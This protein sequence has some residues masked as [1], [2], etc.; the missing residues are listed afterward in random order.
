MKDENNSTDIR[1]QEIAETEVPLQE[2]F[3]YDVISLFEFL[4]PS[5]FQL[6]ESR[7]ILRRVRDKDYQLEC[8][9]RASKEDGVFGEKTATTERK[10]PRLTILVDAVIE[11]GP[12][13]KYPPG[14]ILSIRL[15]TAKELRQYSYTLLQILHHKKDLFVETESMGR[16]LRKLFNTLA[17]T[18]TVYLYGQGKEKM[19]KILDKNLLRKLK[20]EIPVYKEKVKVEQALLP[21]VRFPKTYLDARH[22][23]I[24]P[25]L[26]EACKVDLTTDEFKPT[27]INQEDIQVAIQGGFQGISWTF[28]QTKIIHGVFLLYG[29]HDYADTFNATRTDMYEAMGVKKQ[30][31]GGRE[32]FVEGPRG[33]QRRK[34]DKE[35]VEITNKRVPFLYF[36][37]TGKDR[38]GK[39]VGT[40]A[41]DYS[42]IIKIV[43]IWKEVEQL[44]FEELKK[45]CKAKKKIDK[46]LSHYQISVNKKIKGDVKRYYRMLPPFIPQRISEFR[47]VK[48]ER[49]TRFEVDFIEYLY[50]ENKNPV[51]VSDDELVEKLKI[52]SGHDKKYTKKILDRCFETAMALGFVLRIKRG[53]STPRGN[54]N[55]IHINEEKYYRP[56]KGALKSGVA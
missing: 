19:C 25:E 39:T 49:G 44:E 53:I 32:R 15:G 7:F 29:K 21:T 27:P 6:K 11:W 31:T 40:L 54:M 43:P 55:I 47:A 26:L 48:G 46:K 3:D 13:Q 20:K 9:Y 28:D 8:I 18:E 10:T 33:V 45:D 38:K 24:T 42:C 56:I 30:L 35:L 16:E 14:T 23:V 41:L 17:E 52:K 34:F 22:R 12:I 2:R 37:I 51:E 1:L 5:I 4:L 36:A 50:N